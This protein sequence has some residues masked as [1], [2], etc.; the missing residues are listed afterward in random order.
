MYAIKQRGTNKF[1]RGLSKP[2]MSKVAR[3]FETEEEA[4]D[5]LLDISDNVAAA[6]NGCYSPKSREQLVRFEKTVPM[7]IVRIDYHVVDTFPCLN[8]VED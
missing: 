5:Y 4:R 3:L 2:R 1:L 7:A 8:D 6:L